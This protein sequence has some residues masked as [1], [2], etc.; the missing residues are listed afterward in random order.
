MLSNKK[1]SF[2]PLF[3]AYITKELRKMEKFVLNSVDGNE[4]LANKIISDTYSKFFSPTVTEDDCE[5]KNV[6]K[7]NSFS[8]V[9]F[10]D[11]F[12]GIGGFHQALVNLGCECVFA[13]DIDESCREVYRKNYGIKPKG[14]I[15]KIDVNSIPK[16]DVLCAGFPCNTFSK[17]GLQKGFGDARGNLFF[18]ICEIARVHKPRYMILEN[19]RNLANHDK[20]NTWRLWMLYLS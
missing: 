20:G 5:E 8:G 3:D 1:Y 19:V 13:C 18:N 4:E 2:R 10:I 17:A 11:L 12:C 15:R 14:D 16:F 9:K 7:I 6:E